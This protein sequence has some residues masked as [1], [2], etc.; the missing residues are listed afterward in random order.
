MLNI[1]FYSGSSVSTHHVTSVYGEIDRA[2]RRS[3]KRHQVNRSSD[4][5]TTRSIYSIQGVDNTFKSS[6]A[7]TQLNDPEVALS[8]VNLTQFNMSDWLVMCGL[9]WLIE[10]VVLVHWSILSLLYDRYRPWLVSSSFLPIFPFSI[11][12]PSSALRVHFRVHFSSNFGRS[13]YHTLLSVHALC[14][15]LFSW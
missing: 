3:Y 14:S 8:E 11:S 15:V 10:W 2:W 6:T 5:I 1:M 9:R 4:D 13:V 7:S 12:A